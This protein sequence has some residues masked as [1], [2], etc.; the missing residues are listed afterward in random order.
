MRPVE[1]LMT[2][3]LALGC[4]RSVPVTPAPADARSAVPPA[5]GDS[6]RDEP[7]F[8]KVAEFDCAKHDVFPGEPPPKGLIPARTGIR[9][10][11][12]GGPNGAN[13]NVQ[14][15]RCAI[16]I[17]T[18]CSQGRIM[19]TLRVGQQ[20][21]AER[22]AA[23]SKGAA[24]FEVLLPEATWERGYDSPP[25]AAAL[26]L[27]FKTAAFRAQAALVCE[28]PVKASPADWRFTSVA[29]EETFV[30]GFASGE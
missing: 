26:E 1:A 23:V 28:R 21:V 14:D 12:G 17:A 30:A 19:L 10:W 6:A 7:I 13:W 2:A 15:L 5:A 8:V 4:A 29:T 9:S 20:I 22:E 27:P 3:A 18:T 24:D 16:R 25:T 11:N